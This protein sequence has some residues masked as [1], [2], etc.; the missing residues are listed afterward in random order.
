MLFRSMLY[1]PGN[2]Q[3]MCRKALNAGADSLII[4]VS[5]NYL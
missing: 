4:I 2:R 5:C 1:V 3:D